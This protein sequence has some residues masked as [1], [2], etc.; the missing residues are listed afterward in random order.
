MTSRAP[1]IET[2]QCCISL[3]GIAHPRIGA[4]KPLFLYKRIHC[5]HK[6]R[7]WLYRANRGL[8]LG[9]RNEAAYW[10]VWNRLCS[11]LTLKPSADFSKSHVRYFSILLISSDMESEAGRWIS[12]HF[13]A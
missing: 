9:I 10:I 8:V 2:V 5:P 1:F 4:Y 11:S 13:N 7:F 3:T 12:P 6:I